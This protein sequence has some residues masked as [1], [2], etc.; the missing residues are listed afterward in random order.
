M[1]MRGPDL[2]EADRA[3][4]VLEMRRRSLEFSDRSAL[5][6][7]KAQ[8]GWAYYGLGKMDRCEAQVFF[9]VSMDA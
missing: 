1:D 4:A 3:V 9:R 5:A 6:E 7:L 2:T 8:V